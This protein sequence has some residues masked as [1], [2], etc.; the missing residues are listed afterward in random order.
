MMIKD[1]VVDE[2]DVEEGKIL[3]WYNCDL[4]ISN[5]THFLISDD[6]SVIQENSNKIE[7]GEGGRRSKRGWGEKMICWWRMLLLTRKLQK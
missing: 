7:E 5:F 1:V 4:C 3:Q 6:S 2:D